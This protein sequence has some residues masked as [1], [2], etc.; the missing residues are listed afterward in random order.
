M[1]LYSNFQKG[2]GY[3]LI[4]SCRIGPQ[5]VLILERC[6]QL[7]YLTQNDFLIL[8]A[9]FWCQIKPSF[10]T[11]SQV[12]L[13][14]LRWQSYTACWEMAGQKMS[15]MH[16]TLKVGVMDIVLLL[17]LVG[18]QAFCEYCSTHGCLFSLRVTWT[19]YSVM[20]DSGMVRCLNCW[21]P[22]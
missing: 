19:R 5:L 8:L 2:R 15:P 14:F 3:G 11:R 9:L 12:W 4:E 22:C 10:V 13:D 18:S 17:R 21:L 6:K 16:E 7:I 20:P 1:K